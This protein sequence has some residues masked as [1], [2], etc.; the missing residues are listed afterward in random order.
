[1]AILNTQT[2]FVSWIL[3]PEEEAQGSVFSLTQKQLIQNRIAVLAEEKL[4]LTYDPNEPMKFLQT[5][6]ELQGQIG[7]L[8]YLLTMSQDVEAMSGNAEITSNDSNSF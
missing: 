7:I 3:T 8:K 5:E 4:A 1:M 2:S 6:A